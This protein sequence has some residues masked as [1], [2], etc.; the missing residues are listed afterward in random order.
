MQTLKTLIL[1]TISGLLYLEFGHFDKAAKT[2]NT[3]STQMIAILSP[4]ITW[5][6]FTEKLKLYEKAEKCLEKV[7]FH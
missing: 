2:L 6:S 1:T 3:S 7:S 5:A 4:T